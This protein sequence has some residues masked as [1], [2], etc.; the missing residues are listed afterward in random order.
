MFKIRKHSNEIS[1]DEI[2]RSLAGIYKKSSLNKLSTLDATEEEA[3]SDISI[4]SDFLANFIKERSSEKIIPN[5]EDFIETIN[6]M[7]ESIYYNHLAQFIDGVKPSDPEKASGHGSTKRFFKDKQDSEKHTGNDPLWLEHG[8]NEPGG[9]IASNMGWN[10]GFQG[11]P[12]RYDHIS[13]YV[14]AYES[15][16]EFRERDVSGPN[17][18]PSKEP[19]EVWKNRDNENYG[20]E[21]DV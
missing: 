10:D 12:Q 19:M 15:G 3:P 13:E 18:A 17:L 21:W 11:R 1:V 4:L 6:K 8:A 7:A 2:E 9:L 14:S 5:Q 16:K 20:P